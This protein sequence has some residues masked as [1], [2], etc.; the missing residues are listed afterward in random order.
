[1]AMTIA[2][3]LDSRRRARMAAACMLAAAACLAG[4]LGCA[5]ARGD[6]VDRRVLVM[7]FQNMIQEEQSSRLGATLADLLT[8]DLSKHP[9]IAVVERQNM[10]A[11]NDLNWREAGRRADVD[12]VVVGSLSKL[13]DNYIVSIR[14]LSMVTGEVVKNS[15]V[16]RACNRKEDLYP[17][18]VAMSNVMAGNLKILS[19]RYEAWRQR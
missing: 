9:R 14:L 5:R 13:D 2:F 10:P 8:D 18:V 6:S 15:S 7:D 19:E 11:L 17:L 3:P 16:E 4:A 1:M 12:Y